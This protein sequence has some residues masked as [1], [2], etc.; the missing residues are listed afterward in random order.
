M[1]K[2]EEVSLD[3]I[4]K[5]SKLNYEDKDKQLLLDN[6]L[7]NIS[8]LLMSEETYNKNVNILSKKLTK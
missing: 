3:V 7:L 6:I 5:I 4:K 1:D 2:F 8:H